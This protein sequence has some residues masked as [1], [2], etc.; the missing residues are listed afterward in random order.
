M[1]DV[2][3][4]GKVDLEDIVH[5]AQY[6]AGWQIE[7]LLEAANVSCDQNEDG[8]A[9]IALTDVVYLAQHLAGWEDR[10]L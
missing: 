6:L 3:N 9:R 2:N 5:L 10:E 7:I 8:S 4:S 1:G